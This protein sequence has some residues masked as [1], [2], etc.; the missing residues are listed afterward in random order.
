MADKLPK[1]VQDAIRA[2]DD[3]AIVKA[4]EDDA[5]LKTDA[6]LSVMLKKA[7]SDNRIKVC[8]YPSLYSDH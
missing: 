7:A 5:S 6:N 4:M 2:D 1:H 3:A 8:T